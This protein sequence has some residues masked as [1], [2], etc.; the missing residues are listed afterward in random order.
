MDNKKFFTVKDGIG[1]M[2][3]EE[4]SAG[5]GIADRLSK[6][7]KAKPYTLKKI[8][9]VNYACK[10]GR[11]PS[12]VTDKMK[13]YARYTLKNP[14]HVYV[15]CPEVNGTVESKINMWCNDPDRKFRITTIETAGIAPRVATYNPVEKVF[16][17]IF[18]QVTDSN[19][20]TWFRNEED[21]KDVKPVK[22]FV[23]IKTVSGRTSQRL[24]RSLTFNA[25]YEEDCS[26]ARAYAIKW[27]APLG[28][29]FSAPLERGIQFIDADY[30]TYRNRL[31]IFGA[32]DKVQDD[33]D[34]PDIKTSTKESLYMDWWKSKM[35]GADNSD[36]IWNA[37]QY[38]RKTH[39]NVEHNS[40]YVILNKGALYMEWWKCKMSGIG[41]ADTIWSAIQCYK[42]TPQKY[43]EDDPHYITRE[44]LEANYAK[45]SPTRHT[46]GAFQTEFVR[47]AP[48][49][50]CE[51][52]FEHYKELRENAGKSRMW[53]MGR[54]D[55]IVYDTE[56]YD[57]NGKLTFYT[58]E[59]YHFDECLDPDWAICPK[60]GN[61]YKTV[62]GGESG[63]ICG[64]CKADL[65]IVAI[66]PVEQ[67]AVNNA[68]YGDPASDEN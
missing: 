36:A 37:I 5:Y 17:P 2:S 51:A 14:S 25:H 35:S 8:C 64:Y 49:S 46:V 10:F 53:V 45:L 41:D 58:T 44:E 56:A 32:G 57:K 26:E 23:K 16:A 9:E 7:H 52:F 33:I 48:E 31:S 18:K 59:G 4:M 55:P 47:R 42:R 11:A 27:G 54:K 66:S 67:F 62:D 63:G 40:D 28:W 34:K 12:A 39:C 50:E 19:F 15:I 43:A 20:D 61:P 13:T 24:R 22:Y 30:H 29:S 3:Q 60:C 65:N 1:F 68:L 38:S 6:M 21:N